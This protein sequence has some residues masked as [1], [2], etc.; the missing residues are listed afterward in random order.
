MYSIS[1]FLSTLSLR[2]ATRGAWCCAGLLDIS[3]HALLAESDLRSICLGSAGWISIH[4]LLAESDNPDWF[5]RLVPAGFLSTLSLRRA[6]RQALPLVIIFKISIHALLA[7]SDVF[8]SSRS[9]QYHDFYPRSPCGERLPL[10]GRGYK[11][12]IFLSTLSLR[13]ATLPPTT[14]AP[15]SSYFYPR[16][17]CGE[18]LVPVLLSF[19][20]SIISIHALLAESDGLPGDFNREPGISIHALLAESDMVLDCE[21]QDAYKFLSTLSLRRATADGQHVVPYHENFYPRSPCGERL[22]NLS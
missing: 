14:L 16:S 18:R 15:S 8:I 22:Q 10:C 2:R 7:E 20:Y 13:R 17:P 4:A 12:M 5:G 1:R 11:E 21:L 3:I 6:T 9:F 19:S